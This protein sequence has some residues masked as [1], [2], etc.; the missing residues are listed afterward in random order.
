MQTPIGLQLRASR[1]RRAAACAVAG[2]AI[3]ADFALLAWGDWSEIWQARWAIALVTLTVQMGLSRG[4]LPSVGLIVRPVQGWR[5]WARM[6]VWIGLAVAAILAI[7][8]GAMVLAGYELPVHTTSPDAIGRRILDACVYAPLL[9]ETLYRLVLCIPCAAAL[10]AWPT[11]AVSGLLFGGLHM[12]YGNP[13]PE[14]LFGGWFL[15][16][17][18]LKGGSILIPLLLHS[19]GNLIVVAG[20]VAAWSWMQGG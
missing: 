1:G 20:Q 8:L 14:N 12:M 16:W 10:G 6:T 9:E 11:I 7:S 2:L 17:A 19:L 3:S 5:Y 4:D 18:Y 15:A 13:S